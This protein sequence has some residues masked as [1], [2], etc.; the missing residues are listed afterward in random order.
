MG[1]QNERLSN[2]LKKLYEEKNGN[3][4]RH[5]NKIIA[6]HYSNNSED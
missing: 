4:I 5:L 3:R 1:N 2:L 6:K